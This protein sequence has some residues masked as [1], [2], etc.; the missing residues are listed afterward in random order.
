MKFLF[1][2]IEIQQLFY[3]QSV[4]KLRTRV[5]RM[6]WIIQKRIQDTHKKLP[7]RKYSKKI[8]G[9]NL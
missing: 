4:I 1:K 8:R 3:G 7:M 9:D 6:K 2:N 5:L